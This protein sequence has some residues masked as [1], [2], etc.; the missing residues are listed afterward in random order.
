MPRGCAAL[1]A[2]GIAFFAA[3]PVTAQEQSQTSAAPPVKPPPVPNRLNEVLPQWLRVRAEL[4]G[5]LE[6]FEGAGFAAGR[7]DLYWLNRLRLNATV[8]PSPSLAFTVQAQDARVADKT[9]GPI[10][11]PF[12]DQ[13]DL[14]MAYVSI[15]NA[16]TAPMIVQVGRQELAFGDQRLVGH[17]G[18][19]N[20]ARTFDAARVTLRHKKFRLDGFGSSVVTIRDDQFNKSGAG[21]RFYGAYGSTGAL[22]PKSTIEPYLF[23]RFGR[24]L[25][26]EVGPVGDLKAATIGARW[27][28]TVPAGPEYNT[29]MAFQ[30]GSLGPDT[31]R[32]WAGHW[33]VRQTLR[34]KRALRLIGEYN[35][36]SGDSDPTDGTRETFDQLYPTGHDKYGLAD[37]V[38]WRNLHH[39]RSGFEVAPRKRLVLSGSYHSWWL[40]ETHDGLYNAGGAMLARIAGGAAG[41]HIGHELDAQAVVSLSPQ[42]Q[43]S[44]GYAYIVPGEFLKQATP[45]ASY[46]APYVMVTYVLLAEQ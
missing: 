19:L 43:L 34:A 41:R 14:R 30:T 22:V 26:S 8:Q 6:G 35:Y 18:W 23:Y 10:G 40:A 42:I 33:Q 46:H 3:S 38:G 21:N 15:G 27:V 9:V 4:R 16:K 24:D 36:A 2:F 45:G 1:V 37:Q 28:G 12:R 31:V 39:L 20:T 25:R 44:G 11:P 29:E 13:L 5:R 32:A 17:L 7:D